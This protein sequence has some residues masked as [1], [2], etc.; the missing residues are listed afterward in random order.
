MSVWELQIINPPP[1]WQLG[2]KAEPQTW[3]SRDCHDFKLSWHVLCALCVACPGQKYRRLVRLLRKETT[4]LWLTYDHEFKAETSFSKKKQ[5]TNPVGSNH[6]SKM[7]CNAHK[8][9]CLL[10]S[11]VQ[12]NPWFSQ[13]YP[14]KRQLQYIFQDPSGIG[15][16]NKAWYRSRTY[17]VKKHVSLNGIRRN[18]L[19]WSGVIQITV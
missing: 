2:E 8:R 18:K 4:S 14:C 16:T 19:Y 1:R 11:P 5:L 17:D 6:N 12:Y 10:V 13:K 7:S 9:Y 15:I 3:C